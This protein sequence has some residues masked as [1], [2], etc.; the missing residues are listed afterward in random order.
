MVILG[1]VHWKVLLGTKNG[2][3]ASLQRHPV[4]NL[5][6]KSAWE[7]EL[8]FLKVNEL[9]NIVESAHWLYWTKLE[10]AQSFC[11]YCL[12]L[13]ITLNRTWHLVL[14]V[15]SF[16]TSCH[17]RSYTLTCRVILCQESIRRLKYLSPMYYR[18]IK[19]FT[20]WHLVSFWDLLRY[21]RMVGW[22]DIYQEV[23]FTL[24][25]LHELYFFFHVNFT[26]SNIL[27]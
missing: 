27:P 26:L 6:F 15:V 20:F 22:M 4:W 19:T 13:S 12:T 16:M 9:W 21:W 25:W 24:T 18:S 10:V 14:L 3:M 8:F 2:S 17:M 11:R 23:S 1:T 5:Y 7:F